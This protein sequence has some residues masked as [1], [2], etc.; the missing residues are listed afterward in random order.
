[1][2]LSPFFREKTSTMATN[3]PVK[4]STTKE[5][6]EIASIRGSVLILKNGSLR[7]I[8]RVSSMNFELKSNDEQIAIIRGFQN[9]LNSIDFPLQI[10]V[11]SRKLDIN[12][13]LKSLDELME[14]QS[15]ELLRIQLAEYSRF[16][17]GLTELGDIMAKTFYI[18]VPF[19]VVEDTKGRT[20][21]LD[22]FKSIFS[23]STFVKTISEEDLENYRLQINQRID[24][25]VEGLS[26]MG[27]ETKTLA[28]D[29]LIN[30]F[31]QF[32]NPGHTFSS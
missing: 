27:L 5:F 25:I 22:T 9:F 31:Y 6:V 12:P 13:Y 18:A 19:Y 21:P 2:A 20:G 16:V 10:T 1:M 29:E 23:P 32:Y 11:S 8:V 3:K 24:I 14:K 30:L 4:E 17:R 7:S 26:G 28:E 15:N